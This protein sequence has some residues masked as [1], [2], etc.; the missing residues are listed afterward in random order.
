MIAGAFTSSSFRPEYLSVQQS[1][2]SFEATQSEWSQTLIFG[3]A[4][5]E[6]DHHWFGHSRC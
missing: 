2:V 6:P 4:L 3:R 1:E 5:S